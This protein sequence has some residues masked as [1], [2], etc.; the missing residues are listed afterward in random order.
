MKAELPRP[1]AAE[2]AR[3]IKPRYDASGRIV[4]GPTGDVEV[5]GRTTWTDDR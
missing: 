5:S 3:T 1:L 2:L 4:A